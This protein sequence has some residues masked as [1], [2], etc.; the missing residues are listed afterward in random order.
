MRAYLQ[1]SEISN[2]ITHIKLRT[3]RPAGSRKRAIPQGYGFNLVSVPNYFFEFLGWLV[4]AALTGSYAG[5]CCFMFA[6]FLF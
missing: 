5:T 2:L 3:L 6:V 1:F 4:T